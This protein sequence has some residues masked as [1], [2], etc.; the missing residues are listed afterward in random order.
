[1]GVRQCAYHTAIDEAAR[2]LG[3]SLPEVKAKDRPARSG[4]S[5]TP[6]KVVAAYDYIHLDGTLAHQTVRLDP[7]DF[8]QRCPGKEGEMRNGK[9]ARRDRET[10]LWWFWSLSGMEPILYHLPDLIRRES[11][12]VYLCEGEKDADNLAAATGCLTTTCPMGA[13]KW[14]D[15]YTASLVGR[16]VIMV[17]DRDVAGREHVMTVAKR[18]KVAKVE[19]RMLRWD[20]LQAT[21]PTMQ[22]EGKLDATDLLAILPEKHLAHSIIDAHAE[23]VPGLIDGRPEL[24]FPGGDNEL[25]DFCRDL[26]RVLR[27]QPVF[28][29]GGVVVILDERSNLAP[30]R[31]PVFRSW[32]QQHVAVVKWVGRG[33]E[34]SLE[35]VTLTRDVAEMVLESEFF[36]A[37]LREI[38]RVHQ[39]PLPVH[40]AGGHNELLA[41]GYDEESQVYTLTGMDYPR[42]VPVD[43]AVENLRKLISG[44]SFDPEDA[45]RCAAVVIGSMLAVYADC[46]LAPAIQRPVFINSANSEG[47]GK[48]LC[49]RLAICPV[50]GS[51][52]I[53]PP[54]KKD[55]D[56]QKSLLPVV[57]SGRPYL[58]LDNWRG[59]IED[60]ALEA[61]ITANTYGDR[62]LGS[63]KEVFCDKQCLVFITGN[64][65][66][67]NGDMRR[68]SLVTDLFVE[69]AKAEERIHEERLDEIEILLRRREILSWLW[70]LVAD[71][72]RE[73]ARPGS[74]SHGT[75]PEWAAIFGGIM[76]NAGFANPV[77][78]PK[79]EL[80]T[81]HADMT[82][83][84]EG[85]MDMSTQ[86]MRLELA[87]DPSDLLENARRLGC[88]AWCVDSV[89]PE[90]RDARSERTTF[91]RQIERYDRQIFAG[92]RCTAQG[93][94]HQRK[95]KIERV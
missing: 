35:K 66:I 57:M 53:S 45:G 28:V 9:P 37:E 52:H 49:V 34:R 41:I 56:L 91:Y 73:G 39:V 77:T 16:Q 69:N 32:L 30:L 81:N 63:S 58:C 21:Y 59:R 27:T 54:P 19:V 64:Q 5:S 71:W 89:A 72:D 17:C 50:H 86:E 42:D 94:G 2:F 51:L 62:L 8:R 15:S 88:F 29:R 40:R 67:I 33:E 4:V 11:E 10:G 83:L 93:K 22:E 12:I 87:L 20:K 70:A 68:R 1:M 60:P 84:L 25:K 74:V 92:L 95:Y 82:R 78:R 18:L 38:R 3:L 44:F 13:K 14:R 75:F 85:A 76:E 7:K 36:K 80:D 46:L 47:G 23:H 26:G 79:R 61:F 48:T 65:A 55:G 43:I 90:G 6:W 24:F 31:C